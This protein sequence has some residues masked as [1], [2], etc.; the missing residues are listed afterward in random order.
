MLKTKITRKTRKKRFNRQMSIKYKQI[1]NF[2]EFSCGVQ[3]RL[4][5]LFLFGVYCARSTHANFKF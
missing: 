2:R 1:G 4:V 3:M 5:Y